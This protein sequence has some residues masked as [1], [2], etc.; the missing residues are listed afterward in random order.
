MQRCPA[1]TPTISFVSSVAPVTSALSRYPNNQLRLS[2]SRYPQH[3]ALSRYPS[4]ELCLWLVT[5]AF[6]FSS[7]SY[8]RNQLKLSRYPSNQLCLCLV[9]PNTE[10]CLVTPAISFISLLTPP[11]QST[12]SLSRYPN[13]QLCL[14]TPQISFLVPGNNHRLCLVNQLCFVTPT[15][16]QLC[17]SRYPHNLSSSVDVSLKQNL[18]QWWLRLRRR[19]ARKPAQRQFTSCKIRSTPAM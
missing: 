1:V 3:S 18:T 7:V 16:D 13:N 10:L 6:S 14:V 15:T 17:H 4:N 9:P 12:L 11:Q 5:P 19:P 8:P 2:L